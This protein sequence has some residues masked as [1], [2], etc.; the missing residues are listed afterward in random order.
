[1]VK[2]AS[3]EF[4]PVNKPISELVTKFGGQPVWLNGPQ[5]AISKSTGR[6]MQFIC[7]IALTPELFGETS[8]RMAYIFMTH[9]ED[10]EYVDRTWEPDAGENAVIIQPGK[11][12]I[13]TKRLEQGQALYAMVQQVGQK[14]LQPVPVEFAVN[15]D[16]SE[17]PDFVD[18]QGRLEWD[19]DRWKHHVEVLNGNKLG[20]T[21]YFIQNAEF[22]IKTNWRLLLQLDSVRVPFY[23]NF[24]DAGI[25]HAFISEDGQVGKFLW[26]CA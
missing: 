26:Q 14:L 4:I 13:L 24:G 21:P 20:G 11:P 16:F 2:R 3:I 12:S 18:E 10:D 7:Q 19:D 23:I 5:W 1:M 6:P 25:G 8:G 9:D 22:P 17:D 15:L